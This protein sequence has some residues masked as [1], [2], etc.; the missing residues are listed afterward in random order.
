M[1]PLNVVSFLILIVSEPDYKDLL[2]LLQLLSISYHTR[3]STSELE[4]LLR[5]HNEPFENFEISFILA[6]RNTKKCSKFLRSF[7]RK[8]HLFTPHIHIVI[9]FLR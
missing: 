3:T 4:S 5:S 7:W 2:A 6:L 9:N 1:H 8:N